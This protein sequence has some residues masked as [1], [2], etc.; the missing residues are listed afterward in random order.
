MTS[1][2]RCG[3]QKIFSAVYSSRSSGSAPFSF[4]AGVFFLEG[5][6]D[7]FEEDQPED[8]MLVFGG[9]QV[10]AEFIRGGPEG[11]FEAEGAAQFPDDL[12]VVLAVMP[13]FILRNWL[14]HGQKGEGGFASGVA[15]FFS[16]QSL[17]CRL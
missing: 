12:L 11:G 8:D 13:R 9:I 3:T 14:R 2:L 17:A 1:G 5:V 4:T 15:G 7:V 6:G 16:G 10:A